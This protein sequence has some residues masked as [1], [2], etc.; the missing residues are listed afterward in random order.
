MRPHGS[1]ATASSR[2]FLCGSGA[3]ATLSGHMAMAGRLARARDRLKGTVPALC[4]VAAAEAASPVSASRRQHQQQ[5]TSPHV[6][7]GPDRLV[8]AQCQARPRHLYLDRAEA[9]QELPLPRLVPVTPRLA[10]RPFAAAAPQRCRQYLFQQLL[11]RTHKR[12]PGCPPRSGQTSLLLRTAPCRPYPMLCYPSPW[13]GLLARMRVIKC[14]E[15]RGASLTRWQRNCVAGL[16]LE[17]RHDDRGH[18]EMGCEG[19]S[20]PS[21]GT[22]HDC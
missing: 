2:A 20:T 12:G 13:R 8:P 18:S 17:R 21:R 7:H 22:P 3:A 11:D 6:A 4:G 10:R 5:V 9:A 14:M 16:V 19:S 1:E 15:D